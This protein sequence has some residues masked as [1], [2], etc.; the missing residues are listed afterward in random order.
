MVE[1]AYTP[2]DPGLGDV[3]S[4]VEQLDQAGLLGQRHHWHQPRTRHKVVIVEHSRIALEPDTRFSGT[5]GPKDAA[6]Q[7]HS[8]E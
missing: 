6:C 4:A 8:A 3:N 1:G 7:V 5:A 2:G